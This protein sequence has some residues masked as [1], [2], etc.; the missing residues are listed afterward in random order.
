M[1]KKI[2]DFILESSINLDMDSDQKQK[3]DSINVSCHN[4]DEEL[5]NVGYS[6]KEDGFK[7]KLNLGKKNI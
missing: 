1:L 3:S 5:I 4:K 6:K 2:V 7:L